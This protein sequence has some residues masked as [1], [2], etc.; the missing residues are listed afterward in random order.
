MWR[1]FLLLLF[2]CTVSALCDVSQTDIWSC[3][4]GDTCVNKY[5]LHKKLRQKQSGNLRRQ[6]LMAVEG[7]KYHRLFED[8]D[9][10]GNG[11]ISMNDITNAGDSCHRSCIWRQ[12]MSDLLC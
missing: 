3:L 4:I 6:F 2:V 8:C 7:S 11:C 5:Q 12:T 10:D 9:T 1:V